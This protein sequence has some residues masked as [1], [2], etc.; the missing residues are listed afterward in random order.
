M[1][2]LCLGEKYRSTEISADIDIEPAKKRSVRIQR[3]HANPYVEDIEGHYRVAYYYAFL[4]HTISYLKTRRTGRCTSCHLSPAFQHLQAF[5]RHFC[6]NKTCSLMRFFLT[7]PALK[8]NQYL[9]TSHGRVAT[10]WCQGGS[11]STC[12]FAQENRLFYPNIHTIFFCVFLLNLVLASSP[13]VP[14][15]VLR[16]GVVAKGL[17]S[18]WTC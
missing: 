16:P 5:K 17:M 7:L 13:S 3:N 14:S 11:L 12:N 18:I 1:C 2:S 8:V 9:E 6:Q 10:R 4:D 15:G